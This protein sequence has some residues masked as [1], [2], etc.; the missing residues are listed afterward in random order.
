[1]ASVPA[2]VLAPAN[3][4]TGTFTIATAAVVA[5]TTVTITA[6]YN[7]TTRTA[8]LT[9]T[10]TVTQPLAIVQSLALD[11]ASV[12]GGSNSL[13]TITLSS[14][15]PQGG[16]VVSLRNENT[17]AASVPASVTVPA[18]A[19]TATFNVST[20]VVS[21]T[22][23]LSLLATYDGT[24][25]SAVLTVTPPVGPLPPSPQLATLTVTASGRS[26]ERVTSTPT[27]I[28]VASGS[29]G[30][31]SLATGTATTLSVSNGR[32]A[33]WSGAC[34][35]G[36]SKTKSCTFTITGTAAVTANVQ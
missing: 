28:N 13:G 33:I 1:V 31:A 12:A 6:A 9:V 16:A 15:A 20:T 17:V 5:S 24:N 3:S 22:T 30:S 8:T 35:S 34:S 29:T 19:T 21:V 18:G 25:R 2:T 7:G 11:P 10:P 14:G 4:F 26:G 36:G 23:P 27:G 32:D